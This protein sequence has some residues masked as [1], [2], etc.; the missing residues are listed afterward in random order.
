MKTESPF[1]DV[2]AKL[3]LYAIVGFGIFVCIKGLIV[4]QEKFTDLSV[5]IEQLEVEIVELR[6][7]PVQVATPRP[8]ALKVSRA[9]RD[10]FEM[11]ATAYN[12][13]VQSCGKE[14]DHPAYGIT[15]SGTRATKGRTVAVDPNFIALG[16]EMYIEFPK[17]HKEL[18]GKYIAEDIGGAVKGS[19]VD[20]FL[21]GTTKEAMSFGRQKV[22]VTILRNGWK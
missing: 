11:T 9:S 13:S 3:I 21:G 2:V 4:M 12:L 15:K 1:L 20:I 7:T 10:S 14:K 18:N 17:K 16:S 5:R 6:T 19:I 22:L 8:T